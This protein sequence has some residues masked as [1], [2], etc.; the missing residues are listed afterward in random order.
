M[1]KDVSHLAGKLMGKSGENTT[2]DDSAEMP[3][4]SAADEETTPPV[5]P[6]APSAGSASSVNPWRDAGAGPS[7]AVPS[8]SY[9]RPRRLSYDA[10]TGIMNL[11]DDDGW[12]T[13][14]ADADSDDDVNAHGGD[15]GG[16]TPGS[17]EE[18]G[19]SQGT[20][21]GTRVGR[22]TSTYWHHPERKRAISGSF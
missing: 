16:A 20:G 4:D 3:S 9:S 15:S 14:D 22:R 10:A 5:L 13:P 18:N 2:Q 21:S 19:H 11:P 1:R 12:M 7:Q 6:R 8:A 17:E